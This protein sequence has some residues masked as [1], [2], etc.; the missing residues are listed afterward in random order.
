MAE[1]QEGSRRPVAVIALAIAAGVLLGAALVTGWWLLRGGEPYPGLASLESDD[2]QG[3]AACRV[4]AEWRDGKH[5][6]EQ[7]RPENEALVSSAAADH[8]AES[9]TPE[10]QGLASGAVLG[11]RFIDLDELLTACV[12]AGVEM[13]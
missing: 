3:A 7:G 11:V 5:L 1:H 10:I 2:P 8:A 12:A 9:V 6:D 4:L 13:R